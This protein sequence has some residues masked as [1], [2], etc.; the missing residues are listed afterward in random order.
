LSKGANGGG[1]VGDEGVE[2]L[3]GAYGG[4]GGGGQIGGKNYKIERIGALLLK[5]KKG[6]EINEL[7]KYCND[8]LK[9]PFSHLYK[10]QIGGGRVLK[11]KIL[12]SYKI[13]KNKS[14][15]G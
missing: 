11:L 9:W 14:T 5:I 10:Y 12:H 7:E 6:R 8:H 1:R 13:K 2:E 4:G 3:E 15:S